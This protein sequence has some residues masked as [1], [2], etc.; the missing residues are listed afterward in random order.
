MYIHVVLFTPKSPASTQYIT[1]ACSCSESRRDLAAT[2]SQPLTLNTLFRY[3]LSTDVSLMP[4]VLQRLVVEGRRRKRE[5]RPDVHS[6]CLLHQYRDL[7]NSASFRHDGSGG[8]GGC[9]NW[10]GPGDRT[11]DHDSPS[12]TESKGRAMFKTCPHSLF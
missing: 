9:G 7:G 12:D 10:G 3:S 5:R 8:E 2:V 6:E 4:S 1:S 11:G